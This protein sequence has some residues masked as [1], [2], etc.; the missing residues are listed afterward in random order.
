MY[1]IER[2]LRTL[3]LYVRNKAQLEG[4]ITKAY[5]VDECLTFCSRYLEGVDTKFNQP[6]RNDEYY[7]DCASTSSLEVFTKA[8]RPLGKADYKWLNH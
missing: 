8:G 7:D 5:I 6:P 3:K 2:Y 1:P 4:S